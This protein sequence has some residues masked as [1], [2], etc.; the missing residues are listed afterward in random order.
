M[1]SRVSQLS[2]AHLHGCGIRETLHQLRHRFGTLTYQATRDLR[3]V[4][5]LMGHADPA[6]TAGY[7]AHCPSAGVAAVEALPVP[8]P[9]P[10]MAT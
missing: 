2:N 10:V 7:A 8:G 6:S 9:R 4:Q 3:L 5:E 1:P